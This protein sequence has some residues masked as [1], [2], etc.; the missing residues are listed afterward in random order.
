MLPNHRDSNMSSWQNL[1]LKYPNFEWEKRAEIVKTISDWFD[2]SNSRRGRSGKNNFECGLG[3][4]PEEQL[5]A[6]GKMERLIE[7][8]QILLPRLLCDYCSML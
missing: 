5:I 3:V 2:V 8:L 6:L 1:L 7:K 4:H